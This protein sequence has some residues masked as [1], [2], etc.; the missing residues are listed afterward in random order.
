VEPPPYSEVVLRGPED[1]ADIVFRKSMQHYLKHDYAGAIPG[2]RAAVKSSPETARFNFYL[3]A[4]YLLTSQT[5][6]A[7]QPLQKTISLNDPVYSEAAH[8]YL[9][10]S[11]LRNRDISRAEEELRATV[12]LGGKKSDEAAEILR[13]LGK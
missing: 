1:V 13:Q 9:A 11:Y 2:L 4:C 7:I 8:F 3:G 6:L 10:K 5:D 12:K